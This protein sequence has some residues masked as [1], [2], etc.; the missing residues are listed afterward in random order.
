[1]ENLDKVNEK[2]TEI[3]EKEENNIEITTEASANEESTDKD[4]TVEEELPQE[5]AKINEC[6]KEE[7]QAP[8]HNK[9]NGLWIVTFI[10]FVA[11]IV[12]YIL[13]FNGNKKNVAVVPTENNSG[14]ILTINNDS[15]VANYE[16]IKILEGDLQVESE[17]YQK[18]LEN[19]ASSFQTKYNNY[20][21]NV[22]NQV[23]TQT[24]MQNAERDLMKEKESLE[25]L[26]ERYT[27]ILANKEASVQ[28]EVADSIISATRRINEKYNATYIFATANGSAIVYSDSTLDITKEV[29]EEL[30]E[31]Y[32]KS[33]K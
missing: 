8:S 4:A 33:Q 14:L 21:I 2:L 19:R 25:A 13:Y 18:D 24:Q 27:T 9:N 32:R 15:I 5:D 16:L 29:L 3:G 28:A 11:V 17:K 12:L 26:N 10:L 1:M 23:L 7:P 22:Q 6:V 20:M 31:S 30:N